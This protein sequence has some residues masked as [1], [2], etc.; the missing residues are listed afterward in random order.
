MKYSKFFCNLTFTI[1]N[2]ILSFDFFK[3]LLFV[4]HLMSLWPRVAENFINCKN[5]GISLSL[6][7]LSY[8]VGIFGMVWCTA[9]NFVPFGGEL[10]RERTYIIIGENIF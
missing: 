3:G 2:I 8:L 1:F 9:Y 4:V 10:A 6:A 5:P 7:N